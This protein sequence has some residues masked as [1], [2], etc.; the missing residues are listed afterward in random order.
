MMVLS[1]NDI[2]LVVAPSLYRGGVG[3]IVSAFTC[4]QRI[5]DEER[6]EWKQSV[7]SRLVRSPQ[8]IWFVWLVKTGSKTFFDNNSKCSNDDMPPPISATNVL[9]LILASVN[10]P[11]FLEI[12]N[13]FVFG[14]RLGIAS[15]IFRLSGTSIH[16][17]SLLLKN[18]S[19]ISLG[20]IEIC[21]YTL[22]AVDKLA[23]GKRD[24]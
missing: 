12:A 9:D 14:N 24:E 3:N 20:R 19:R 11:A 1:S 23:N 4:P 21:R 16:F 8:L 18:N 7:I 22:R 10:S 2:R 6:N 17:T 5:A 15:T 13:D